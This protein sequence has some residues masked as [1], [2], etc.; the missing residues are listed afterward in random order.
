M[1]DESSTIVFV[2]GMGELVKTIAGDY[3]NT[4]FVVIGEAV[5]NGGK[6]RFLLFIIM[7]RWILYKVQ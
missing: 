6:F 3:K 4:Y 1:G 5:E 2:K 7:M